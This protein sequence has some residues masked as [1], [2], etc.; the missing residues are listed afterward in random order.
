MPPLSNH[1]RPEPPLV[2]WSAQLACPGDH[3]PTY[4][5][6]VATGAGNTDGPII[7]GLAAPRR[8]AP[9]GIIGTVSVV[10]RIA[11]AIAAIAARGLPA[12]IPS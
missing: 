5:T 3:H 2:L 1:E 7:A 8:R 9:K 4:V 6:A 11:V 10:P 12:L